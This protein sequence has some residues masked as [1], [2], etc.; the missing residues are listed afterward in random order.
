M[1]GGPEFGGQNTWKIRSEGQITDLILAAVDQITWS[2]PDCPGTGIL[3][4]AKSKQEAAC[5]A[6]RLA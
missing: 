4:S 5:I 1:P 2:G 3:P 6:A